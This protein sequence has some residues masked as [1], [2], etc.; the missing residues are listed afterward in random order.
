MLHDVHANNAFGHY[1]AAA[2]AYQLVQRRG[3]SSAPNSVPHAAKKVS[4]HLLSRPPQF[5]PIAH[6]FWGMPVSAVHVI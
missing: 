3:T 6:K 5:R 1:A 4:V 2:S